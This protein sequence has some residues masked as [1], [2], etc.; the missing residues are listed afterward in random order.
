MTH[1]RALRSQRAALLLSLLAAVVGLCAADSVVHVH[2]VSN[3]ECQLWCGENEFCVRTSVL[4]T[5]MHLL[6]RISCEDACH[7]NETCVYPGTLCYP[8]PG[9]YDCPIYCLTRLA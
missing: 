4:G 7:D 6:P 2:E 9:L 8:E 1:S 5:C 3:A